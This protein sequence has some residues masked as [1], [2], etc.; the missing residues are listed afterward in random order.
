MRTLIL[1]V[2]SLLLCSATVH[3]APRY[4][5]T[6]LPQDSTS[7]TTAKAIN[8]SG[9]VVQESGNWGPG[10]QV[11]ITNGTGQSILPTL[12][13][14]G[15]WASDI[16]ASNQV[17]GGSYLAGGTTSHAYL[18]DQNGIRDIGSLG[19][20][21][22]GGSKIN[23]AGTVIGWSDLASGGRHAFI[24]TA[25]S[26]LVDIGTLGGAESY[27]SDI[28]ASGRVLGTAQNSAGE[29]RNYLY[30]NGQMTELDMP[31]GYLANGFLADG[32][33]FGT[34]QVGDN[35]QAFVIRNGVV[36]YPYGLDQI[37]AVNASGLA[38]G[39]DYSGAGTGLLA[40][41]DGG[42]Y[43]LGELVDEPGWEFFATISGINDAGQIIGFACGVGSGSTCASVRLD[44]V[45]SVPE[46]GTWAMLGAG[47]ALTSW[48]ARR[49]NR[50]TRV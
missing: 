32:G 3:A 10:Y 33:Y 46:P 30:Q 34:L 17:V 15:A 22:A 26:G 14:S 12:G 50:A 6:V 18:Y 41:P 2:S 49:R 28:D 8:S 1:A 4:T 16:N 5:L 19:G 38:V 48:T 24:Y 21:N 9:T 7:Q 20:T 44:P 11:S 36:S 47:L 37:I 45:S 35:A 43:S 29:W 13:G 25:A 31:E 23:D 39:Y 40:T 27:A 42:R